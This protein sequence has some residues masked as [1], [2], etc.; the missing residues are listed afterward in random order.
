MT[1]QKEAVATNT[2]AA[3]LQ[4]SSWPV[5]S[6]LYGLIQGFWINPSCFK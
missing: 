2:H 4:I 5:Y 1:L 6:Y 3:T